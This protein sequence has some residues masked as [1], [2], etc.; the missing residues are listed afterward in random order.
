[1]GDVD[2]N[3]RRQLDEYTKR[4]IEKVTE[5]LGELNSRIEHRIKKFCSYDMFEIFPIGEDGQ[6]TAFLFLKTDSDV[7]A[8][9]STGVLDQVLETIY[10]EIENLGRGTRENVSVYLD[11]D[12]MENI[13]KN[14][15]GDITWR[16][17]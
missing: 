5:G 14:W 17:R 1:M 8:A 2:D 12:S 9:R 7:D 16:T 4:Y 3:M 15:N 13:D 6:T 11:V 10:E